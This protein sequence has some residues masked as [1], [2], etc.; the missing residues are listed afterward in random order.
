[1]SDVQVR[2]REVIEVRAGNMLTMIVVNDDT[3]AGR[4]WLNA[5]VGVERI[6]A[7]YGMQITR[8]LAMA[9]LVAQVEAVLAGKTVVAQ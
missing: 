4:L 1:M 8:P 5:G 7:T 6:S 9:S 3:A 2:A